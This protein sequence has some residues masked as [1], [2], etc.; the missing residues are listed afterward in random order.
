MEHLHDVKLHFIF[1]SVL[2][3][4]IFMFKIRGH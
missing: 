4:N 2:N 3:E 1:A